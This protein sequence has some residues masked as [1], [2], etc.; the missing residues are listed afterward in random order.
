MLFILYSGRLSYNISLDG[1]EINQTV[2][3][4]HLVDQNGIE[5]SRSK[6]LIGTLEVPEVNLWW[7]HLM[8]ES[9]GY[10]YTLKVSYLFYFFVF[11]E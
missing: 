3:D 8:N 11:F 1:F 10:L 6:G 4:C 9:V 2:C 5:V 7:P